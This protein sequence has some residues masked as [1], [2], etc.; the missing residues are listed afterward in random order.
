MPSLIGSYIAYSNQK[1][2][3]TELTP[4]PKWGIG[5]L[6][7]LVLSLIGYCINWEIIL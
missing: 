7:F 1:G 3:K 6:F 2:K 5:L 4:I